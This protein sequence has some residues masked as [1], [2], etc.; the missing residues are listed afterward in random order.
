MAIK[1]KQIFEDNA[2][3]KTTDDVSLLNKALKLIEDQFKDILK[4]S[5]KLGKSSG[6]ASA[7]EIERLNQFTTTVKKA[8]DAL[9]DVGKT[10][11]K[12]DSERHT[13]NIQGCRKFHPKEF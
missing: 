11:K 5:K 2:I 4:I 13:K 9:E 10:R 12:M 1:N 7:A 8:D 3:S 6:I